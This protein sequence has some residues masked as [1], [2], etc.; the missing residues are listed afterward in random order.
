MRTLVAIRR[1][2]I[3]T[4]T[5]SPCNAYFFGLAKESVSLADKSE[6]IVISE[7]FLAILT[8]R[9]LLPA[10]VG[11]SQLF[12]NKEFSRIHERVEM[13]RLFFFHVRRSNEIEVD[14]EKKIIPRVL[15]LNLHKIDF[16]LDSKAN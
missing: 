6:D 4:E 3:V 16:P 5:I 13:K 7:L 12:R 10:I 14:E 9:S 1:V 2:S 11:I 8:P 15:Q